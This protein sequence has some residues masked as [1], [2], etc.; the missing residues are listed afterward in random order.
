MLLLRYL[1]KT[2]LLIFM[3]FGTKTAYGARMVYS[4]FFHAKENNK[5]TK[6]QRCNGDF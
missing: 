2:T 1:I 4:Y 5:K 6:K 3:D